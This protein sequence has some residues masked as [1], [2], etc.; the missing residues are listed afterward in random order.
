[1]GDLNR[2]AACFCGSG[3]RFKHCHGAVAGLAEPAPPPIAN[4]S[5]SL[6]L[7]RQLLLAGLA[8]QERNQPDRARTQYERVLALD[9]N[10]PDALHLLAL[11]DLAE[12]QLDTALGRIRKAIASYP[13]HAPYHLAHARI[14]FALERDEEAAAATR[15]ASGPNVEQPEMWAISRRTLVRGIPPPTGEDAHYAHGAARSDDPGRADV[16]HEIATDSVS[17]QQAQAYFDRAEVLREQGD[18]AAA[19]VLLREALVLSPVHHQALVALGSILQRTYRPDEA[20]QIYRHAITVAPERSATAIAELAKTLVE[21]GETEEAQRMCADALRRWPESLRL[22]LPAKLTLKPVYANHAELS[23]MRAR[24]TAGLAELRAA[25]DLFLRNGAE[26]IREALVWSNFYLAYQGEND[27]ALQSE[28]ADFVGHLLDHALPALRQALPVPTISDRRIRIGFASAYFYECSAGAYFRSWITGLDRSRFEIYLY[29]F[30]PGLDALGQSLKEHADHFRSLVGNS[31]A[32]ATIRSDALD[33]LVYP[34][35]GADG[36][37]YPLGALRLAPVQCAGW[38]HPVTTGHATIDYFFSS[39]ATEPED[40]QSHY[41]ERL[42]RLPGFGTDYSPPPLPEFFPVAQAR[43]RLGLPTDRNLYLYPQSIYKIHPDN[44]ALLVK[45]LGADPRGTLVLF[46][47]HTSNAT[48]LFLR[49]IGAALAA[50]GLAIRARVCLLPI[51]ARETYLRVNAACDVMLDSLHWSG[52]NTSL[53]ALACGLPVVTLPGRYMR[54]RQTYGMLQLLGLP[55]LIAR[56]EDDYLRI[57]LRVAQ[58]R[59]WR[60]HVV[61]RIEM[62]QSR[63]FRDP[64]PVAAMQAFYL[65]L[66]ER[67]AK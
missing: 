19:E 63:L 47:G 23:Q 58:D 32:G 4:L 11:L 37:T 45:L 57:A 30:R 12:V 52:G 31:L 49:R 41:R 33:V 24:Y 2:N 39:D 10:H 51:M 25:S 38:G 7:D 26:E 60:Q 40:A 14:L 61:D 50:H 56:D 65:S 46:A 62:G 42:V 36:A 54:G 53:D 3:K 64:A 18:Y 8:L 9:A 44:D 6:V 66:F 67:S 1:M 5:Q 43:E 13:R 22:A 55:E 29:H 27:R 34:E 15:Y 28:Y 16:A 59:D 48:E 17:E 35:L 20:A 21:R